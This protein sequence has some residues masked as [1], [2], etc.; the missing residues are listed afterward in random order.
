L[1]QGSG[2]GASGGA[3][4]GS[5]E[6]GITAPEGGGWGIGCGPTGIGCG[7]TGIGAPASGN[8]GTVGGSG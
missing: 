5:V 6:T 1:Y 2:F 7:P 3:T 8:C 4:T